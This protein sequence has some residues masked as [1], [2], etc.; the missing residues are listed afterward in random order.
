MK[1]GVC[2]GD[3]LSCPLFDLAIEPLACC[4]W[5]DPNIKG[6]LIPGIKNTIK[7]MLFA[8]DT[9]LFLSKDDRLDYIQQTLDEW[10]KMSGARFNIEKTEVLL[11]E[12]ANHRR[13]VAA[14]QKINPQDNDPLTPRI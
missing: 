11:I 6:I 8:D 2:Q 7:I 10:C 5:V 4:I 9:N 14:T 3:P 13:T 1:C 12:T